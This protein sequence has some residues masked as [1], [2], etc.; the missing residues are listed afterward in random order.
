VFKAFP[1]LALRFEED[2][3]FG[4]GIPFPEPGDQKR[5]IQKSAGRQ[6]NLHGRREEPIRPEKDSAVRVP[7]C[8]KKLS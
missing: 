3:I 7:L 2:R 5:L 6:N 4:V 8:L 1:D